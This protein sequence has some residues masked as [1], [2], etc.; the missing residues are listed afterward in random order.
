MWLALNALLP[1][2]LLIAGG[3]LMHRTGFPGDGFWLAAERLTYFVLFPALLFSSLATASLDNA[4]VAPM[5][6]AMIGGTLT[7]AVIT[8]AL[9]RRV[10]ADGP[11][12]SSVFQGAVRFNTYVAITICFAL[13]GDDGLALAAVA[14]AVLVPLVNV[15]SV[16]VLSRYGDGDGDG[17]EWLRA[18]R[19]ISRNPLVL[20]CVF[21]VIVNAAPVTPPASLTALLEI[22][23]R[24]ALP[25][26]LL[27]VGAGLRIEAARSAGSI[28][29]TA[30][31]LR[32]LLS[33]ALA[34][35]FCLVLGLSGAPALVVL[36]FAAAP[37]ASSAYVLAG[38]LGGDQTLMA[39]ILTVQTLLAVV[40]LPLLL[41]L[42]A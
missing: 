29:L 15:L 4:P 31:G 3:Y 36:I 20:A 41:V 19:A 9:R 42:A 23:G 26:G 21:G 22:L 18:A 24:A 14:I 8:W 30:S 38:Q 37:G 33:P 39:S 11:G 7:L 2:F 40:T 28:A 17:R 34:L 1:V 6:T 32:L 13:Y 25:L 35:A 27:A 10:A 16:T 12:F 5:A